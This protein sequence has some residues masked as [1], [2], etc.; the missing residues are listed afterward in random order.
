MI[1]TNR[2]LIGPGSSNNKKFSRYRKS[3][4]II[5]SLLM[6]ENFNRREIIRKKKEKYE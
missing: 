2:R 1:N 3:S 5:S 6:S 4:K